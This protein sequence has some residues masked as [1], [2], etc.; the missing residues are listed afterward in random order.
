MN[1]FFILPNVHKDNELILTKKIADWLVNHKKKVYV[2]KAFNAE[3]YLDEL[4]CN[5]AEGMNNVDC[6]IVLGGDGT[7]INA[8][9]CFAR[10]DIP[11]LGVNLGNLGFLAEVEAKDIFTTLER[12][13]NNDYTIEKRM[14]LEA[15]ICHE[16]GTVVNR[17]ALNDMVLGRT[18][19][20]RMVGF[21]I[22]VNGDLVNNYSADGIIIATP[23]G[24]TAYNLSAGGPILAPTNEMIVITPICSHSLTSRSIVIS[25]NDEVQIT[26]E[27]N[28]KLWEDD[29]M[30]TIDGQQAV[31]ISKNS[32]ITIKKS[33]MHTKL[34]KLNGTNFYSLLRK[35][36]AKAK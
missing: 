6:A 34:I 19:I 26:F 36:L 28:R 23:T 21:S 10:Q 27:Y 25:G 24:S 16:D 2:H 3:G 11:F 7:I 9:R 13:L 5:Q 14:M 30:L 22:Y 29:L 31:E 15:S 32:V 33:S 17:V 18:A 35:K 20:S 4:S 1:S 8:S 12:V